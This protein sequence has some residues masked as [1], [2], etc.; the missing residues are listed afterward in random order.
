MILCRR[1]GFVAT[2]SEY[3]Q[4]FCLRC[5]REAL[6]AAGWERPMTTIELLR[7]LS[8]FR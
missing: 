3:G 6:E 2:H 4:L 7:R 5:F 8:W 1:H